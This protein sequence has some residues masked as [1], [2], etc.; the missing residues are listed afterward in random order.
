MPAR[1]STPTNAT[2]P[3][4]SSLAFAMAS[5]SVHDGRFEVG[6]GG[7]SDAYGALHPESLPRARRVRLEVVRDA[8]DRVDELRARCDH[9]A[10]R[11]SAAKE[12]GNSI[13]VVHG[14]AAVFLVCTAILAPVQ[15][16][17]Y[18]G[19]SI[20]GGYLLL[21][22]VIRVEVTAATGASAL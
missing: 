20:Y 15:P 14:A 10:R 5:T 3:R 2:E 9:G 1:C 17:F 21:A 16:G 13:L 8:L 19:L 6:R 22:A 4:F 11:D 7:G 18:S 12:V